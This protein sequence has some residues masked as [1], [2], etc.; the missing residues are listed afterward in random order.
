[1]IDRE[2]PKFKMGFEGW[3]GEGNFDEKGRQERRLEDFRAGAGIKNG[4]AQ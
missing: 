2:W 3:L 4:G 1:M